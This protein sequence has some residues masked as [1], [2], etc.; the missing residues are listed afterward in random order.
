[1]LVKNL[2]NSPDIIGEITNI[3]MNENRETEQITTNNYGE[4]SIPLEE[5]LPNYDPYLPSTYGSISPS[6]SPS[7]QFRKTFEN[8]LSTSQT[9][10]EKNTIHNINWKKIYKKWRKIFKNHLSN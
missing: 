2:I 1:M 3:Y 5:D 8:L 9:E 4:T 6:S 7:I 10:K